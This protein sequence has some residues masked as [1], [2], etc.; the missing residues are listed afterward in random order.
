[1]RY[2]LSITALMAP[3][4]MAPYK[5][6]EFMKNVKLRAFR[7]SIQTAYC[8]CIRVRFVLFLSVVS[9]LHYIH[10]IMVFMCAFLINIVQV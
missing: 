7:E 10:S 4:K 3:L 1:M 8:L 6:C 5:G 2:Y 9:L